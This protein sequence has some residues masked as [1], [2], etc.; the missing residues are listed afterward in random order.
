MTAGKGRELSLSPLLMTMQNVRP[1]LE[2][3]LTVCFKG[4]SVK[5]HSN[6]AFGNLSQKDENLSSW[7]NLLLSIYIERS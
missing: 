1:F 2:N 3:T 6:G 5:Q 7:K 4:L